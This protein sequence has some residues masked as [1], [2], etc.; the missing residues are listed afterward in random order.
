MAGEQELSYPTKRERFFAQKCLRAFVK[1]CAMQ[2]LG[3]DAFALLAVVVTQEDAKR[4]RAPVT[5][6]NGQLQQVLGI[7]KWDRLDAVRKRLVASGWL[8]YVAPPAGSRRVPGRYWGSI[9]TELSEID[10]G[11]IDE[12]DHTPK[13]DTETGYAKGG[14]S[15]GN[16]YATGYGRGYGRGYGKGEPSYPSPSPSPNTSLSLNDHTPKTDTVAPK[17][18][19]SLPP[20]W[21]TPE[22]CEALDRWAEH[23]RQKNPGEFMNA[24]M[25]DAICQDASRRKW[26]PEKLVAAITFSIARGSRKT[27]IDPDEDRSFRAGS[28]SGQ[29]SKQ[30]WQPPRIGGRK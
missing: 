16:G 6:Y 20:R 17:L 7:A 4:Y 21:T 22:V 24:I 15:P 26:G 28:D 3:T 30:D 13:P 27:I 5:F 18:T 23:Y 10:D 9:P 2:T 25:A 12:G 11:P 19:F 8:C 14:L 1:T 29:P